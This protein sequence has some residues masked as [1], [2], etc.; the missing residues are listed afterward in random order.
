MG[1]FHATPMAQKMYSLFINERFTTSYDEYGDACSGGSPLI[2]EPKLLTVKSICHYF[3]DHLDCCLEALEFIKD[4]HPRAFKYLDYLAKHDFSMSASEGFYTDEG[5]I[6]NGIN[7]ILYYWKK[8]GLVEQI[9]DGYR[10]VE[11]WF[12]LGEVD[13]FTN[14]EIEN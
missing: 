1:H 10:F 11:N 5:M 13:E 9:G 2:E 6:S 4:S 8:S 7:D 12:D 3:K 14:M